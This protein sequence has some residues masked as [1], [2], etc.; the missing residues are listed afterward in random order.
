MKR[1]E[2]TFCGIKHN[3]TN[4]HL[5]QSLHHILRETEWRK[6]FKTGRLG[7]EFVFVGFC[8]I[9]QLNLTSSYYCWQ[10]FQN[11]NSS[12]T[13]ICESH[14]RSRLIDILMFNSYY[15]QRLLLGERGE[16]STSHTHLMPTNTVYQ[17]WL[18]LTLFS[19]VHQTYII[20]KCSFRTG[21]K[22]IYNNIFKSRY[23]ETWI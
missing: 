20:I 9:A 19:A 7:F 14:D 16:L 11:V 8:T 18:Y 15:G 21:Y 6:C 13:V 2:W 4:H 5:Q 10:C 1:H 23:Q 3:F 22:T 17:S 12:R